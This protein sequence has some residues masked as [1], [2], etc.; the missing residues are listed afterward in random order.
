MSSLHCKCVKI[1]LNILHQVFVI[2]V[3]GWFKV[4][5]SGMQNAD[6]DDGNSY[7][8]LLFTA[9]YVGCGEH[10]VGMSGVKTDGCSAGLV[11]VSDLLAFGSK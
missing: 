8:G 3:L 5:C 2:L 11:D 9:V 7:P 6:L 10:R 1:K 4:S